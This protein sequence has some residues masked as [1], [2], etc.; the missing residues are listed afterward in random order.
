M[1]GRQK[2]GRQPGQK[3][4]EG[5]V[6]T[7]EPQREATPSSLPKQ[8]P[9][10]CS[11]GCP[12]AIFR[13]RPAF[14]DEVPLGIRKAR[15]FAR[16]SVERVK[17]NK[18]ENADEARR[19][20]TPS[21]AKM[22]QKDAEERHSDGGRK[23]CHRV[24]DSRRETSFL[25]RKPVSDSF[26]ICRESGGLAD[27]Q[28]KPRC[29]KAAETGGHCGCKGGHGPENRADAAYPTNAELVQQQPGR[30]LKRCVGPVVGA[31]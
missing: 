11:F 15:I 25:F 31:R 12:R 13:L 19:S 2:I 16:V 22:E 28:E 21:P 1:M 29:Q 9:Q 3:K 7:E 17:Q 14:R 18:I 6:V 27:S 8:I 24:E 10:R 26:G 4:I 20:E 30:Q 5:V 23:F